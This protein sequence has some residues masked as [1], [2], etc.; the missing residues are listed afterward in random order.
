MRDKKQYTK[1]GKTK[2]FTNKNINMNIF[3][4]IQNVDVYICKSCM[5]LNIG[6]EQ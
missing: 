6:Q 2:T 1:I 5:K 3:K 4:Y